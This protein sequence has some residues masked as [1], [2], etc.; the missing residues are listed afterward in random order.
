MEKEVE[1]CE[2]GEVLKD[3]YRVC[4]TDT[5]YEPELMAQ[6]EDHLFVF[7]DNVIRKGTA[8]Q[9]CIRN[10]KN[11]F[12][13]PT[14]RAP[15]NKEAAFFRDHFMDH[16]ELHTS[17]ERLVMAAN[18]YKVIVFPKA[19]LGTGLAQM[20]RTSP[21]LFKYM[22]NFLIQEFLLDYYKIFIK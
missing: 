21:R 5:H 10:I 22:N 9:A 13:I 15:S 17:L 1:F 4:I 16:S 12:G 7:G 6:Y 11:S 8:G 3:Q 18:S 20:N 14:K 2:C 19:G